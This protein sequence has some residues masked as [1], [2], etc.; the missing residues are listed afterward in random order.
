MRI[1][2]PG[3]YWGGAAQRGD[4]D[5]ATPAPAPPE[6]GL[7][8]WAERAAADVRRVRTAFAEEWVELVM[9]PVVARGGDV[10]YRACALRVRD[11]AG[12][13]FELDGVV[14]AL[15]QVGE[16]AW[17]DRLAVV[18]VLT[19]LAAASHAV[20]GCRLSGASLC[21]ARWVGRLAE[22]LRARPQLARRL[23]V[24]TSVAAASFDLDAAARRFAALRAAGV[25]VAL[26]S[27]GAS[28]LDASHVRGLKVDLVKLDSS[29]VLAA[30]REPDNWAR[31]ER[32]AR[33]LRA[34]GAEV[35][36]VGVE[37]ADRE[38][39]LALAGVSYF[40]GPGL[41]RPELA[42]LEGGARDGVCVP[43]PA[44]EAPPCA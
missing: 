1:G 15:E 36:L 41:G 28:V 32:L 37:A 13:P 24:E 4:L 12:T 38:R 39:A 7:L 20:L 33:R 30:R 19:R 10:F 14:S 16:I 23:V 44:A 31:I 5:D 18:W 29:L 8:R 11:E 35:A 3:A 43:R 21:E 42:L 2:R 34:F 40:Q 22:G 6:D 25:H 17:L 26:D 27:F 9:R